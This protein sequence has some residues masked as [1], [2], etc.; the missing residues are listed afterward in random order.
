MAGVEQQV[1]SWLAC[2][3]SGQKLSTLPQARAF[4][5][6]GDVGAMTVAAAAARGCL[7][8]ISSFRGCSSFMQLAASSSVS[9]NNHTLAVESSGS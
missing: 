9:G 4:R 6:S 5:K 2:R 3:L 1:V 7:T 8:T